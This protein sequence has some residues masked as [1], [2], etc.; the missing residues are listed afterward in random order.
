MG[1]NNQNAFHD[2]IIRTKP[3]SARHGKQKRGVWGATS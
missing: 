1:K 3:C 2:H